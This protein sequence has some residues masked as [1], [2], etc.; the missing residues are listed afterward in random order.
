[1]TRTADQW[2][3]IGMSLGFPFGSLLFA[4]GIYAA[5]LTGWPGYPGWGGLAFLGAAV[6]GILGGIAG[7][8]IGHDLNMGASP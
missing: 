7:Y 4:L 3:I 2:G 1:M 6:T 5:L 8:G